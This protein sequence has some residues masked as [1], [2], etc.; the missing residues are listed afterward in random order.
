MRNFFS[1]PN[2]S[3]RWVEKSQK[4]I[5]ASTYRILSIFI[6]WRGWLDVFRTVDWNEVKAKHS[7]L[8][9]NISFELYSLI[10]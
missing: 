8:K 6:S 1:K 4:I 9:K 3:I 2:I 5:T 10:S 7:L